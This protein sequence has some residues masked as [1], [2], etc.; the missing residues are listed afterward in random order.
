MRKK[1]ASARGGDRRSPDGDN[2]NY[3]FS[4]RLSGTEKAKV[5]AAVDQA[6]MALSAWV[7]RVIVDAAERKALPVS[8]VYQDLFA[9]LTMLRGEVRM[10]RLNVSNAIASGR[11][12]GD[13]PASVRYL[14]EVA[15]KIDAAAER[16]WRLL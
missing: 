12:G 8:Q 3:K 16:V 7:G 10:A 6:G 11:P 5:T 1:N 15:A 14:D 2:R 9:E 4:V 13:L